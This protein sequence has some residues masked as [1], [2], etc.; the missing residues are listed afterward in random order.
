[1]SMPIEVYMKLANMIVR[2][3]GALLIALVIS[4]QSIH[5]F[6]ELLE[7]LLPPVIS[8]HVLDTSW[9][10][11]LTYFGSILVLTRIAYRCLG[12]LEGES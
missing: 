10:A 11:G 2:I 7:E 12:R 6:R 4:N 5:P 9:Y 3:L 1:M 8:R